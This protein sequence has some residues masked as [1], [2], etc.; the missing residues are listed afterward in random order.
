[1]GEHREMTNGNT[2]Q[3]VDETPALHVPLNNG[4]VRRRHE[5]RV[6]CLVY[7]GTRGI[8]AAWVGKDKKSTIRGELLCERWKTIS[9]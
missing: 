6:R 1:M 8:S 4:F 3:L 9:D 7:S 5:T 2:L